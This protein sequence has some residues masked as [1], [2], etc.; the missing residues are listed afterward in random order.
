MKLMSIAP[1]ITSIA[2]I[3][4][5]QFSV[6]RTPTAMA[7]RMSEIDGETIALCSS[8]VVVS[9]SPVR[10]DRMPPVFISQS[11]GSGRWSSRS[12]SDRGASSMTC[13]FSRRWRIVAQHADERRQRG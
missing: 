10:R 7:R 2:M 9:T 12:K 1:G 6:S 8:P 11:C 4:S 3:A 13:V 5:R